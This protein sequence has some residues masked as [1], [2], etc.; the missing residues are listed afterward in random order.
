M[1]YY[2]DPTG[3]KGTMGDGLFGALIV[4]PTGATWTDPATGEELTSGLYANIE[5]PIS[6]ISESLPYFYMMGLVAIAGNQ[7][8]TYL[9]E[10]PAGQVTRTDEHAEQPGGHHD[11]HANVAAAKKKNSMQ[12]II[13]QNH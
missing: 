4:E 1:T 10:Q 9:P 12:S 8:P 5:F 3:E 11:E 6:Q 13:V 2:T 7:K